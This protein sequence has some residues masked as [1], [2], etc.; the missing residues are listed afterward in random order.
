VTGDDWPTLLDKR[1]LSPLGMTRTTYHPAEPFARGYV[2]HPYHGTL[3]EEPR[4]D[5]GAM[6]PAGQLWSTVA[7]L[8]RWAAFLADPDPDVLVPETVA[9]M[10]SPVVMTDPDRWTAGHGLG[11]VLWRRGERVFVGHAGSMPGYLATLAVHR[12]S[13]TGVVAFANAYTL[14]GTTIT[15]LGL[16]LLTAVLDREPSY[17]EPW[18]AATA[19]PPAEAE[20]LAG[21]WW[22]MGREF[23]VGWDADREELVLT[24]VTVPDTPWRFVRDSTDKWRGR[25]GMNDGELLRVRRARSGAVH[26]LDIATFVFTR[27]P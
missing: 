8:S 26:A 15:D 12:P 2:V 16:D 14:H 5:S 6:A 19:P 9:E 7:D 23:A 18:T 3:R 21:R 24:P 11:L 20:Q 4:L 17:P 13:R 25:A 10:C 22:W 27:E 1:V